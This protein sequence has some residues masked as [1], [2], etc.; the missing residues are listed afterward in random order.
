M[1][2]VKL[3]GIH[4]VPRRLA[5]GTVR[6]H[7]YA[8]RPR[9]PKFW[10]SDSN[11]RE[12]SAEYVAAFAAAAERPK[13]HGLAVSAMIDAYLD[14]AEFRRL[15]D[16]TKRDYRKFAL[17]LAKEFDDDPAAI[18][19]DP[20]SRGEVNDWRQ[21]WAHSP[22]QFDYAGTVATV[23]LNWAR[24]NGK[25]QQ[26]HCDRL[27]KLYAADRA[28]IVWTPG[29]IA[30]FDRTAPEWVRRILTV[31]VET[32]LRPGDLIRLTRGNI[33]M[34]PNGRQVRIRTN[35]RGRTATIPVTAAL[36]QVLDATPRD[37]TL[38]LVSHRGQ[39]LTEHRASEAVRQWR[40][41]AG[42]SSDLR[43]YDARG[44]AATRLLRADLSL[45]QIARWMGWSVRYAQNVIEHYATVSPV[46]S[47]E[48]LVHLDRARAAETGTKV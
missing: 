43:L 42:L 6:W 41:K 32:G 47:D 31:A 21:K 15:A 16:R 40:D 48:V 2:R 9:G 12:G 23:I 44:T 8:W 13:S 17:D 33:E 14:S 28:E 24:D 10:S 26:H 46:E 37:R 39:P 11:V 5:D 4:K 20:A 22:K 29:D 30:T 1:A 19:E 3:V 36:A 34:T 45:A 35:K 7:H 38:I 27:K 18:F 25:I